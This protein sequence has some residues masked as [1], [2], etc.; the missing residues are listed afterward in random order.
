MVISAMSDDPEQ[1]NRMFLTAGAKE[2]AFIRNSGIYFGFGIG[3]IQAVVW[4]LTHNP[5]VIPIFGGLTGWLSDWLALKMIFEPRKP[6]RLF[7]ILPWHGLFLKRRDEVAIDYGT[8]VAD[9]VLTPANMIRSIL[10][11]PSSDR[12]YDLVQ[13]HVKKAVDEQA[14]LARPLMVYRI[15]S[16]NY[17]DMKTTAARHIIEQAPDALKHVQA[18]AYEAMDLRNTLI[19][20]CKQLSDEDFE[21]LLRPIFKA[22]EWKLIAAGAVLGFMVGELQVQVMIPFMTAVGP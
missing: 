4:A 11:G 15:G 7:G 2:M 10:S 21:S 8:L 12:L 16:R 22:E 17:Q 1:L 5:W 6:G 19:E 20:K 14:G 3:V 13:K 9:E 18:Y